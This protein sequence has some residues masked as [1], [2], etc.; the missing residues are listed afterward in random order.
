M[1]LPQ[2]PRRG[3]RLRVRIDAIDVPAR[4]I[5]CRVMGRRSRRTLRLPT[6]LDY[7][8]K[9]HLKRRAQR[10]DYRFVLALVALAGGVV[11]AT[12]LI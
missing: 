7:T 2:V 4:G 12:R 6:R 10:I 3:T 8:T 9:V 11:V 1:P 5:D